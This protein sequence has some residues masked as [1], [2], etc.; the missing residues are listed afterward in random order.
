MADAA[1]AGPRAR[2]LMLAWLCAAHP[3]ACACVRRVRMCV[4]VRLLGPGRRGYVRLRFV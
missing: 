2:A 1:G 3:H 4:R